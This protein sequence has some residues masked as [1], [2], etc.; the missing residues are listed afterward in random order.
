M[1]TYS[2]KNVLDYVRNH[3]VETGLLLIFL[4]PPLG[5]AVLII[6]GLINLFKI[7]K[8]KKT[9]PFNVGSFFFINLLIASTGASLMFME[10]KYFMIPVLIA[11]Y[12]GYYLY[13]KEHFT[14]K[15]LRNYMQIII[16]G[17]IYIAFIGQFQMLFPGFVNFFISTPGHFFNS[18]L[19]SMTGL[20]PSSFDENN[21]LFGSAYNPNFA[22]FF[23]L[24]S[25]SLLLWKMLIPLRNGQWKNTTVIRNIG[26]LLILGFSIIQ[27]GSRSGVIGMVLLLVIFIFRLRW[28]VGAFLAGLI[29]LVSLKFDL[30]NELL[31]RY[32]SIQQSATG[33]KN[34]W[35]NSVHIW[36]DHPFFGVT[37]LGFRQ[38][39]DAF[40]HDKVAHAHNIFLG[41]FT[42][43]G[44]MGGLAFILL[45][46]TILYK[47]IFV[48]YTFRNKKK[49]LDIFLLLMPVF[50]IT[51]ILDHPLI[52]P[53]T[54]LLAIF[55]IGGWD[56]YVNRVNFF[57]RSTIESNHARVQ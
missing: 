42:E 43:Y 21:R 14:K 4:L 8:N 5:I 57:T 16:F 56:H 41:F 24:M 9:L 1:K 35:E 2:V 38:A 7:F 15:L 22:A 36:N 25:I 37:P 33:R 29:A 51:G 55:L 54:A 11:S 26:L 23:L 53:Q 30:I 3:Y 20:F 45:F 12:L 44:T 10:I 32:E 39:Y 31:P 13:I 47:V 34:I 52:S 46:M 27:T 50:L 18:A 17:G 48:L 28:Q 49:Y 6:T 40:A 19:G